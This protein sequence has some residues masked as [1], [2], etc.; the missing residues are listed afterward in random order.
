MDDFVHDYDDYNMIPL[1]FDSTEA[2]VQQNT[3]SCRVSPSIQV[4]FMIK[5]AVI[6]IEDSKT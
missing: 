3:K 1:H 2:D 6:F 5:M 4:E